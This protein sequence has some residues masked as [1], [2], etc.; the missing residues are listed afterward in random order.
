MTRCA[1][2]FVM[3]LATAVAGCV[4]AGEDAVFYGAKLATARFYT[5]QVL[6]KADALL[7]AVKT[8]AS[9]ALTLAE[10]QF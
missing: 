6:P 2:I 10:E 4:A 3:S 9:A 7:R 5:D 1:P 8:G